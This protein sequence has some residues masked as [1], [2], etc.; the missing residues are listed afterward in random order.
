MVEEENLGH[1]DAAMELSMF[2]GMDW[3][4]DAQ[5]LSHGGGLEYM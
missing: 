3:D 4:G 5:L 2:P 1:V